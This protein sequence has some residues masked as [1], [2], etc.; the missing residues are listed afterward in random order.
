L[1]HFTVKLKTITAFAILL[2]LQ[3]FSY[4]QWYDP[5][6]VGKKAGNIYAQAYEKASDGNYAE[7]MLLLEKALDLDPKFVDVYLSRAGIYASMKNYKASVQDFEKA[8]ELD[9]VYSKT[10]L[11]PYAISLAGT[12]NF[13]EALQRVNEFLQTPHLNPQS[14]KAGNYR[15]KTFE[16]ALQYAKE[17]P[18][19]NY[20]FSPRNLGPNVNSE[21]LEYYPSIT[22]DSSRLV[23]SRMNGHDEDFYETVRTDSG[24]APAKPMGGKINTHYNEGAQ[25]LSQDGEWFIFAGCGYPEGEGSCDLYFCRKTKN[26]TW[27]EPENL[28]MVVNSEFWDSSPS[29]SPDKKDLY[30]S[31]SRPGGYGGKDLYVTHRTLQG[32]WTVPENLGPQIN[33]AADESCSFIHADNQT[34]YFN[35][36]GHDGYGLTDLFLSRKNPDGTWGKPVNLGYPVNTI[37]DEGSLIVFA[38]GKTSIYA[39]DGAD[40]Y[41]GLDLYSFELRPDIR[42]ERTIWVKGRVYDINTKLGL[43]STVELTDINN[44]NLVSH[45]QTDEDGSYLVT[46][47]EGKDYAFNVNR[48]GYLFYSQNFSLNGQQQDSA[49]HIN[50]PLQPIAKGSFV[51]LKNIFYATNK[52]Q[53]EPQSQTELNKVVDFLKENPKVKIRISGYTDNIGTEKDNIALSTNRAK[54]VAGY[55]TENGIGKDRVSFKGWGSVQPVSNNDTEEG[56]ALNRRTEL[57]IVAVE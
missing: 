42:A 36:S 12:G 26:G 49:F 52:F 1:K 40:T 9:S 39:S 7:S 6:K 37:D 28:G 22:I 54:A 46:L 16:F 21:A 32:K 4:G 30:F 29:L 2:L 25:N 14:I 50:I 48:K 19:G 27:T 41:G 5:D 23:F 44:R 13:E 3:H 15:K 11:L 34:L 24:W 10:Y 33:T 53:L 18:M 43:P 55:L 17:H 38:D 35:S 51:V 57:S 47:P 20:V 56:R 45:L 31:S 8:F